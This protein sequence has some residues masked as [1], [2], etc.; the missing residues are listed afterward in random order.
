LVDIVFTSFFFRFN[1]KLKKCQ[2]RE[3]AVLLLY[4]LQRT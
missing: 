1:F 4:F 3:V 2:V